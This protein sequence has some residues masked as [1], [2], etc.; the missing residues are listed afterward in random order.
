MLNLP[1]HWAELRTRAC[2]RIDS[3]W[4][5]NFQDFELLF[6]GLRQTGGC[7]SAEVVSCMREFLQRCGTQLNTTIISS[8][9]QRKQDKHLP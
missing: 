3:D 9:Q 1:P 5:K 7:S 4:P 8:G 6:W 2:N